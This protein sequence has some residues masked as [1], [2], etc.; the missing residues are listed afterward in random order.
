MRDARACP[1][2]LG[3]MRLLKEAIDGKCA[4]KCCCLLQKGAAAIEIHT[5]QCRVCVTPQHNRKIAYFSLVSGFV[6]LRMISTSRSPVGLAVGMEYVVLPNRRLISHVRPLPGIPR[7]PRLA[8]SRHQSPVDR[9]DVI[10]L[11]QRQNRIECAA[12]IASHVFGADDRPMILLQQLHMRFKVLGPS[13]VV[14]ADHVGLLD[15]DFGD[16]RHRGG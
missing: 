7:N 12:D 6:R 9:A 3:G 5:Q 11:R 1:G 16:R 4:G 15:L 8:L 10:L 13:V 2:K 14:E